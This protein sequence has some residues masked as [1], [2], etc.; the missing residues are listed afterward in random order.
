MKPT[1]SH[2]RRRQTHAG[3]DSAAADAD[4]VDQV[5]L[6]QKPCRLRRQLYSITGFLLLLLV[7]LVLFCLAFWPLTPADCLV[8]LLS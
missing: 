5:A 7:L 4:V 1:Q 6:G 8:I 2:W 3:A